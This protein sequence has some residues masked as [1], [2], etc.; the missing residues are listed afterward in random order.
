MKGTLST[1]FEFEIDNE[2][3]DDME[4]VEVMAGID[5]NPLLLPKHDSWGGTEA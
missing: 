5:E 3:L 4:I 1:G 2:R